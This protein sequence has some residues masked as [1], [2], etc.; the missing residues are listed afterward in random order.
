MM[1]DPTGIGAIA[2]FY[3]DGKTSRRHRVTLTIEGGMVRLA[4]DVEREC[5]FGEVRISERAK[6]GPRKITF[7]DGAHLEVLDKSALKALLGSMDHRDSLV[8]HLQQ[9]WRGALAALAATVAV[10]T[11]GY[12]YGLPLLAE[13]VANALPVEAER[14]LGRGTLSI[15]D[16]HLMEPTKLPYAQRERITRAFRVLATA[17][18]GAPAYEI[19][20]RKSKIGPNAF[21]L[22]SGQIIV[23]DEIVKLLDDEQAVMGILGHELGH[24][25]HRHM[26]RRII[27]STAIAATATALFGDVSAVVANLPT[28]MLDMRY[29]RDA[30]READD[31][32]IAL[33]KTNGIDL[34][35]FARVFEKLGQITGEQPAYLSSHPASKE[36]IERIR[37]A[38]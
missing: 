6:H 24:L 38:R 15:L 36:R 31:Y 5:L 14:A 18:P 37:N 34:G 7:A 13:G 1:T 3:Y 33:F 8:V 20:F 9:S 22:P 27:Q 28:V 35:K 30:E 21:A 12:F 2:A 29:S 19:L 10:L 26:T 16:A 17:R 32:G 4:G 11:L 25:Q 23:T